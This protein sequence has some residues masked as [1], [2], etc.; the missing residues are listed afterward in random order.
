MLPRKLDLGESV[1]DG[2]GAWGGAVGG[3]TTR[4]DSACAWERERT[5]PKA[6]NKVVKDRGM[7]V[8]PYIARSEKP[9]EHPCGPNVWHGGM[10]YCARAFVWERG[11]GESGR[12]WDAKACG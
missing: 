6:S 10:W 5:K 11:E 7:F 12:A 8:P 9:Q 4:R 1:F 3:G 2:V